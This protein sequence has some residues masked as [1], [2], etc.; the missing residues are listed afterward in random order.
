MKVSIMSLTPF[1]QR[2]HYLEFSYVLTFFHNKKRRLRPQNSLF[3]IHKIL[4]LMSTTNFDGLNP[5][6]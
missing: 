4:S 6:I 5:V 3:K 2:G 1:L